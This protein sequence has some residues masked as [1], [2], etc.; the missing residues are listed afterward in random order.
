MR[1][2]IFKANTVEDLCEACARFADAQGANKNSF[3]SGI[4]ALASQAERSSIVVVYDRACR[5]RT[6]DHREHQWQQW[7]GCGQSR[8]L[9]ADV[10]TGCSNYPLGG[11]PP[12]AQAEEQT[13]VTT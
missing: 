7:V 13:F 5:E 8:F 3:R 6:V 12:S 4:P 9:E 11:A 1:E 10:E 2:L